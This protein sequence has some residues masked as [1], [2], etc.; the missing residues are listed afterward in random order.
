M[1]NYTPYQIIEQLKKCD[2]KDEHGHTLNNNAAFYFLEKIINN[3]FPKFFIGQTVF[4]KVEYE[5]KIG[6]KISKYEPFTIVGMA[7][8]S[9]SNSV[10]YECTLSNNP[11]QP[12]YAGNIAFTGVK[13]SELFL[14]VPNPKEEG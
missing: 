8:K 9:D 13:E 7:R 10:Y 4:Y 1:K 5:S 2:F 12:Y 11:C 14:D 6:G 3:N